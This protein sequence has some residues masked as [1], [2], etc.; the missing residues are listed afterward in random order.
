[1]T[2]ARLA[3]GAYAAYLRAAAHRLAGRGSLATMTDPNATLK[4]PPAT[5][6]GMHVDVIQMLR[7]A[8]GEA[9]QVSLAQAELRGRLSQEEADEMMSNL[10]IAKLKSILDTIRADV[11]AA[12]GV[13]NVLPAP[14]GALVKQLAHWVDVGDDAFKAVSK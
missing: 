13:A 9:E 2:P 10:T 8:Q 5:P 11:D 6:S 12:A 3:Q 1:M 7:D 4:T 14:Y